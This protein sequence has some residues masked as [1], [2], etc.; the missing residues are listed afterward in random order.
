[1]TIT[2]LD[3]RASLDP[4]RMLSH[5]LFAKLVKR[6]ADEE[7]VGS[8]YAAC[9]VRQTLV[10]LKACADNTTGQKLSP[11][12]QIDPGWH[13]FVLH[14]EDYAEFCDRIAGRFIHHRPMM[15]ADIRSGNALKRTIAALQET[16][17]SVDLELWESRPMS[18][19]A[20]CEPK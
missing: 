17:Y 15:D 18:C 11:S 5:E 10:F 7:S 12:V 20:G 3:V 9:I 4:A 8:D 19:G 16:G 13:A 14:A 2:T 6:V 1:M